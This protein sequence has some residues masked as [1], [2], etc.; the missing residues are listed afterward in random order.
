[1]L[2]YILRICISIGIAQV[3]A[4]DLSGILPEIA[5]DENDSPYQIETVLPRG[6][7]IWSLNWSP[8]DR[9]IALGNKTG[10]RIY[11]AET[12]ALHRILYGIKGTINSIDWSPDNNKIAASG[13]EG[14]VMVWDVNTSKST[15]LIGHTRQVRNVRWSPTGNFLATTSHDGYIKIWNR[16]YDLVKDIHVPRGGC[17][18]IDWLND[19]EIGASCWDN[20]VRVFDL[21]KDEGLI[22][23]NG[24]QSTKAVLSLDWHSSGD[25]LVTGDYGNRNDPIHNVRFWSPDGAL[26]KEMTS[27]TKEIR[28]LSWNPQGTILATGGETVRLWDKAGKLLYV[29][30]ANTSPVWSL[31]WNSEGDKI[32]SG[33]NDGKVRFWDTSG[34]LLSKIDGHS[35]RITA[36][37]FSKDSTLLV[38]GFSDGHIRLYHSAS[39]TSRTY[40]KHSRS[41]TDIAWS[42]SGKY[43]AFSSNDGNGSIWQLKKNQITNPILL[44]GHEHNLNTVVWSPK[45]KKVA[46]AGYEKDVHIW[47]RK[48]KKLQKIETN[49]QSIQKLKWTG[50]KPMAVEKSNAISEDEPVYIRVNGDYGIFIPLNNNRFALFDKKGNLIKGNA[51]DF[52]KLYNTDNNG[53]ISNTLEFKS[54]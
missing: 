51:K 18:S 1:M 43:I 8:D 35:T 7:N 17:V 15:N 46:V 37:S 48:G 20:T 38:L 44:E 5:I 28:A 25:F 31:D 16:D 22:F 23:A 24:L 2:V 49:F 27:H 40:K 14:E 47:H 13:P 9:F 30:K 50:K 34:K 54:L 42:H 32:V 21:K 45:D 10:L 41:I 4:Q 33:H 29:F 11:E 12:L 39:M 6:G 52:V 19:N 3:Y 36:R 26:L 53:V